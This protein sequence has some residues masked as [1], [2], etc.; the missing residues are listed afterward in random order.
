VCNFF[1]KNELCKSVKNFKSG[2]LFYSTFL[3][4]IFFEKYFFCEQ[5]FLKSKI[6]KNFLYNFFRKNELC[7]SVKNFKSGILF[8]IK[9]LLKIFFEKYFF[10]NKNF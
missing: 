10:V 3:L 5:K 6:K 8:F 4:K 2:I 1:R 9:F 7:K